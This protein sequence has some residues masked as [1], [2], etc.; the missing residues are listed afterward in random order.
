MIEARAGESFWGR[1]V[2]AVAV[3]EVAGAV[4]GVAGHLRNQE[5]GRRSGS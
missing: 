3:S 1:A 4:G 5:R 2:V